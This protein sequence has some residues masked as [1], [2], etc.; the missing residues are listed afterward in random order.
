MNCSFVGVMFNEALGCAFRGM[1][2][3]LFVLMMHMR[4]LFSSLAS[5]VRKGGSPSNGDVSSFN[6]ASLLHTFT[7]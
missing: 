3:F 2:S 6:V 7:G 5:V 4:L 1:I